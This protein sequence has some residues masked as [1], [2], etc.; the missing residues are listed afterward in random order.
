MCVGMAAAP[1]NGGCDVGFVGE[2]VPDGRYPVPE[3]MYMADE[4]PLTLT[5]DAVAARTVTMEMMENCMM[6]VVWFDSRL[7][8]K[9]GSVC[10]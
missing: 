2:P 7:L 3:G 6:L 1:V 10:I 5:P 9:T 8:E 4:V